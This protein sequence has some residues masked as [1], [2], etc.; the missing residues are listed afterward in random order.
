MGYTYASYGTIHVLHNQDF[1]CDLLMSGFTKIL[2]LDHTIDEE[3]RIKCILA[4]SQKSKNILTLELPAKTNKNTHPLL[5][6][7]VS[8]HV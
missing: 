6:S 7:L 5:L 8:S 4:K 2:G 1:P 3:S